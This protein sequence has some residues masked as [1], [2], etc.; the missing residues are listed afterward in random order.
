MQIKKRYNKKEMMMLIKM[1]KK[2]KHL[3][4]GHACA[5]FVVIKDIYTKQMAVY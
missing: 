3:D 2:K 1:E 4:G 5:R